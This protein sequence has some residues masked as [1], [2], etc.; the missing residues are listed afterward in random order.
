MKY[1]IYFST[2]CQGTWL[3]FIMDILAYS[4][5]DKKK[6]LNIKELIEKAEAIMT[7]NLVDSII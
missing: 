3:T 2:I 5:M 6:I 1:R 7:N 4:R